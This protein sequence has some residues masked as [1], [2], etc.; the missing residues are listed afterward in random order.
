[1]V[2]AIVV[3]M[4]SDPKEATAEPGGCTRTTGRLKDI[5][6]RRIYNGYLADMCSVD[7][8]LVSLRH[9]CSTASS[10]LAHSPHWTPCQAMCRRVRM[11]LSRIIHQ[12]MVQPLPSLHPADSNS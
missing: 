8:L 1:M 2:P 12:T 7:V 11:Y 4:T 10:S 5:R 9:R 6:P 3:A